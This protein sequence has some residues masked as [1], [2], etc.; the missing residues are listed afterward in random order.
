MSTTPHNAQGLVEATTMSKSC[1]RR[2]PNGNAR[3]STMSSSR[4]Q[5]PARYFNDAPV[6]TI[7][8]RLAMPHGLSDER[9]FTVV[10]SAGKRH[11]AGAGA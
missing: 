10:W 8:P 3:F 11:A 9:G 6:R 7:L 1:A 5:T 2:S 4:R